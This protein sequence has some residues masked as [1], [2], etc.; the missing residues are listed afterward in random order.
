MKVEDFELPGLC[1]ICMEDLAS[2]YV[3]ITRAMFT[4]KANVCFECYGE[5][6]ECG[7]R[8][9]EPVSMQEFQEAVETDHASADFGVPSA[10]ARSQG[11]KVQ[12]S[13]S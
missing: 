12:F 1:Q 11:V 13:K 4:A 8:W 7:G 6:E 9:V 5:L 3:V 2:V 10:E